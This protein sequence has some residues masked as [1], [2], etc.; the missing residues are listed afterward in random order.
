MSQWHVALIH[1][2]KPN[3]T[4][5]VSVPGSRTAETDFGKTVQAL[6][7]ALERHNH[8]VSRLE[9]DKTLLDAIWEHSPDICFNVA[10]SWPGESS[11]AYVPALLEMLAIPHTGSKVLTHALSLNKLFAK[12]IWRDQ[13][14]PTAPFQLFKHCDETLDWSM[15]FPLF[16]KPVHEDQ[17]RGINE[18]SLIYHEKQLRQQV[19]WVIETYHQPALVESYLPGREFTVGIM[20]NHPLSAH[21]GQPE[22]Y[23]AQGYHIFPVLEI[24]TFPAETDNPRSICP[25]DIPPPFE[26]RL[27]TLAVAAFEALETLD[28]ARVD[29]R[30]DEEGQ[31]FLL[32]INPLPSLTP[33]N[34]DLCLMAQAEGLSYAT[35]VNQILNLA[36]ERYHF[37][38]TVSPHV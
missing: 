37:L 24:M 22:L 21:R 20:G 1:N 35:L 17:R 16:V 2:V 11:P 25:A 27:K 3:M 23:D 4:G 9:A 14:L 38:S 33:Q 5:N 10:T 30:L 34:S 15:T 8:Q 18:N 28:V 29:F 7:N 13:G 12:R 26:N 36:V 6:E 19:A 31:P 32:E